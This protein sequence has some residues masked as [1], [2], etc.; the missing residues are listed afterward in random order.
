MFKGFVFTVILQSYNLLGVDTSTAVTR[1]VTVVTSSFPVVVFTTSSLVAVDED[2]EISSVVENDVANSDVEVVNAEE[3]IGFVVE[4][5]VT[6]AVNLAASVDV[7]LLDEVVISGVVV[8]AIVNS[9]ES[10]K[11]VDKTTTFVD[12]ITASDVETVEEL[13]LSAS[14]PVGFTVVITTS[15]VVG[16]ISLI[17]VTSIKSAV[18]AAVVVSLGT[19]EVL[20]G[21]NVDAITPAALSVVDSVDVATGDLLVVT[22][23]TIV[24][25]SVVVV[26]PVEA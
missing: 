26:K 11:V 25:F 20:S 12:S 18:V 8:E 24:S 13:V 5:I 6:G 3:P 2:D 19:V 10:G 22:I 14:S 4:F 23:S 17:V 15:F 7:S 21:E 9:L 16:F 1:V